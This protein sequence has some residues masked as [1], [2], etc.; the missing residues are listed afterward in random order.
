MFKISN[1][2]FFLDFMHFLQFF[3]FFFLIVLHKQIPQE[4]YKMIGEEIEQN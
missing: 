1:Q 4:V 3:Y 2:V